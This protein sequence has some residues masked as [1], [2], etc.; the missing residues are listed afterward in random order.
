MEAPSDPRRLATVS[1]AASSSLSISVAVL[2]P[3]MT[4][5]MPDP[6]P[7]IPLVID[8]P[9]TLRTLVVT[10]IWAL[11]AVR[12]CVSPTKMFTVEAAKTAVPLKD[13]AEPI[14]SIS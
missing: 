4:T 11:E 14:L 7:E 6:V 9:A 12:F 2:V 10:P 1:I 3:S 8:R 5:E 13:V